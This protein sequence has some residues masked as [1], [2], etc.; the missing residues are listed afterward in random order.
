MVKPEST[1]GAQ[2]V[3]PPPL[4]NINN[5]VIKVEKDSSFGSSIKNDHRR[6]S[7]RSPSDGDG[8]PKYKSPR[9]ST[10]TITG[11]DHANSVHDQEMIDPDT[12]YISVPTSPSAVHGMSSYDPY[13]DD[14]DN[15]SN[16]TSPPGG[17]GTN[18]RGG[19]H[20]EDNDDDDDAIRSDPS[21]SPTPGGNTS[22]NLLQQVQQFASLRAGLS[23]SSSNPSAANHHL[24][25]ALI[26]AAASGATNVG[27]G[28]N[29]SLLDGPS[30]NNSNSGLDKKGTEYCVV[31]GDKASGRHYGAIS[32]EGCKGF[33]KRSVRKQLNYVCRAN[34]DCE[35]TKHHRNRCQYCRLQK[36]LTMGMR[37]DHCQ[38]ERKPLLLDSSSNPPT[39]LPGTL[40]LSGLINNPSSNGN[41]PALGLPPNTI[42]SSSSLSPTNLRTKSS[43]GPV[44]CS[45]VNSSNSS[46]AKDMTLTSTPRTIYPKSTPSKS[47]ASALSNQLS[48]SALSNQLSASSLLQS[49]NEFV[50][51]MEAAAAAAAASGGGSGSNG[52]ASSNQ[53]DLSTLASVVS[54]LVALRQV[55][56][57]VSANQAL[58]ANA[59]QGLSSHH[60]SPNSNREHSPPTHAHSEDN[61]KPLN[62]SK[63][64]IQ[65]VTGS[66]SDDEDWDRSPPP[67]AIDRTPSRNSRN[68]PTGGASLRTGTSGNGSGSVAGVSGNNSGVSGNN[69]G[70]SGNNPAVSGNNQGASGNVQGISKAAF[71]VMAKLASSGSTGMDSSQTALL[72]GAMSDL[73]G[74]GSGTN[75]S[76]GASI[77][78]SLED[79]FE[80]EGNL[81]SD[82]HFNFSLTPPTPASS[83]TFLSIQYI[84]ESASRLLF[85]SVHWA[86]SIQAFQL[87]SIDVQ[88]NLIRGCWCSLFILGLA[89][90]SQVMSLATILSAIVT[91]LQTTLQQDKLSVSRVKQVTD[92]ICKLQ[93][94]VNGLQ[95]LQ[96]DDREYAYL[97]AIV[98]F[99]PENLSLGQILSSRQ[100][101][102]F[103][104]KSVNELRGYINQTYGSSTMEE[105]GSVLNEA[106]N[107]FAKLILRLLPLRS[108]LPSITE[109]L[110]F[111]GLIGNVQIDSIIP[112]ILKMD[113]SELA[114]EFNVS[115][116]TGAPSRSGMDTGTAGTPSINTSTPQRLNKSLN[117]SSNNNSPTS[118]SSNPRRNGS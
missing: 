55:A 63:Q 3:S 89:Q 48:A 20:N 13:D 14:E 97:K 79:L 60:H 40:T 98:L 107:R 99:T 82:Q 31:C 113:S 115:S 18:W 94:F 106:S 72:W 102:K 101:E 117:K 50:S 29:L 8:S 34:Q 116:S 27:G 84:C 28:K 95:R 112:Y 41:N 73:V 67:L 46:S 33:F 23:N 58:A 108:I 114:S 80:I 1:S 83:T 7:S 109:E 70:V 12:E 110:F 5:N 103:Q 11:D 111:S 90:C 17:D 75:T 44:N 59:H 32:C 62:M 93:D 91:H 66:G 100:I 37:A 96:V 92:H 118:S 74:G 43:G 36:C 76:I 56:A 88:T 2:S 39:T 87:M 71:D 78:D 4:T 19:G 52:G 69:A 47:S 49:S 81:L 9:M 51:L 15:L 30:G 22:N 57:A 85:L 24:S 86:Q 61:V 77:R 105:N 64:A 104:E 45:N 26:A 38:P 65:K 10:P 16:S 6:S 53:S 42:L 68:S 54:N 35:V 21:D 25:L